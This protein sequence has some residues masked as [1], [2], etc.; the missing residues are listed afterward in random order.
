MITTHV[1][2]TA[3]GKPAVGVKIRLDLAEGAGWKSLG[4]GTTDGDGRLRT[5][6]APGS[7]LEAGV[8]GQPRLGRHSD[9][10]EHH[11]GGHR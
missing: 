11:V 9:G 5:L 8:P 1:L 10:G 3:L 2:D 6:L 4:E 7:Q